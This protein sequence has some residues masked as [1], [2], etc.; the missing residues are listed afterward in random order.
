MQ[1][2]NIYTYIKL[3][4]RQIFHSNCIS[5]IFVYNHL[6][7]LSL[8][9]IHVMLQL[10]LYLYLIVSI[11]FI[12]LVEDIRQRYRY[13]T[14][15]I[16][17]MNTCTT[18]QELRKVSMSFQKVSQVIL[19]SVF[20][21]FAFKFFLPLRKNFRCGLEKSHHHCRRLLISFSWPI[22]IYSTDASR[23]NNVRHFSA[24]VI[25]E[26]QLNMSH[27]TKLCKALCCRACAFV[28]T[29]QFVLFMVRSPL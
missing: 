17:Q 4:I 27:E 6:A 18:V 23:Q 16:H 25:G 7:H 13:S 1:L 19:F 22:Y 8:K 14:D 26:K 11:T 2:Y 28:H 9:R 20:A 5:F 15:H 29:S 10:Q 21:V 24:I 3:F 12:H